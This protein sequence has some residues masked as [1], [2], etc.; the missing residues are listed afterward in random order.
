MGDS[1]T[2]KVNEGLKISRY[3][4]VV[5]SKDFLDKNWPKRELNSALNIEA[6]S[7]QVRVLPLL[8]GAKETKERIIQTYPIL[9]DKSYLSW[10]NDPN[11]IVSA[12]Q[13]RLAIAIGSVS[14]EQS[15]TKEPVFEVPIPEIKR[16]FTQRDKDKFLK[17][18]FNKIKSY[19]ERALSHL[20][21]QQPDIETDFTEIHNFKFT[22][23]I[24]LHGDSA[25][26]CKIWLGGPL[27]SES[28]AY[29]ESAFDIDQNGSCNDWLTI[30]DEGAHL[31]LKPSGF[32]W[33]GSEL[34]KEKPLSPEKAG[35]YFW[36]RFT[37][38]LKHY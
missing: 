4:I 25:N 26:K 22:S 6:S 11:V 14:Q 37:E 13:A 17:D 1:I 30:S 5:L 7:G 31:G 35:E 29:Y 10:N 9:N 18:A 24:Y 20:E 16:K 19:F 2:E 34:E 15:E 38:R 28:I 33:G 3:V 32:V 36:R 8:A 27:S 12:L 23:T 21:S